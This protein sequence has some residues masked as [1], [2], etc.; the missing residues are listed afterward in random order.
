[1]D[2]ICVWNEEAKWRLPT[3]ILIIGDTHQC[4]ALFR[5]FIPGFYCDVP[6]IFGAYLALHILFYPCVQQCKSQAHVAEVTPDVP[7]LINI[8][9]FGV[10]LSLFVWGR[11]EVKLDGIYYWWCVLF[12]KI[13]GLLS[14]ERRLQY[15]S[16][17]SSSPSR[18]LQ[19]SCV[20]AA[21]TYYPVS[22]L[23]IH[24]YSYT[25]IV[26]NITHRPKVKT[27]SLFHIVTVIRNRVVDSCYFVQNFKM[28]NVGL[29]QIKS[30]SPSY[31]S[32][33]IHHKK[34]DFRVGTSKQ[35]WSGNRKQIILK[36]LTWNIRWTG[37][38]W[39]TIRLRRTCISRRQWLWPHILQYSLAKPKA[40]P[41]YDWLTE[42]MSRG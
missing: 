19:K 9:H 29:Q 36:G 3:A 30:F 41:G 11:F 2:A 40:K 22:H 17:P 39:G 34:L 37:V 16:C 27:K 42:P 5:Y 20:G 31:F 38:G 6:Y 26:Q 8:C 13:V 35:G 4:D 28:V 7:I 23:I 12:Y 21:T 15:L 14:P 32:P 1:M 18:P 25:C 33:W 10:S 24:L